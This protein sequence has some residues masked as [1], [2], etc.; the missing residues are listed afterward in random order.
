MFVT[1]VGTDLL[2]QA[3]ISAWRRQREFLA[4]PAAERHDL[5]MARLEA[6]TGRGGF[7]V[8]PRS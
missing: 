6:Q 1:V 4:T 3:T 2:L 8:W 5:V 7:P